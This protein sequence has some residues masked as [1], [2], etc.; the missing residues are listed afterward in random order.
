VA[1]LASISLAREAA[2][3]LKALIESGEFTLTEPVAKI[4]LE[5]TFIPQDRWGGKLSIE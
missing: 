1:P 5:R 4:N 3:E 2:L